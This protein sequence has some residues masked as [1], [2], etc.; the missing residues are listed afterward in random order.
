[1]AQATEMSKPQREVQNGIL[2]NDFKLFEVKAEELSLGD[3]FGEAISSN[4]RSAGTG[5]GCDVFIENMDIFGS[6]LP[7]VY[8]RS[9]LN[10]TQRVRVYNRNRGTNTVNSVRLH[11][12]ATL[13]IYRHT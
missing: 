7:C 10:G 4:F 12:P 2:G 9:F 13:I 11:L 8:D 6:H 5:N 3:Y 1:M